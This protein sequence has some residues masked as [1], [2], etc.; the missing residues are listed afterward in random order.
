MINLTSTKF[1]KHASPQNCSQY[2]LFARERDGGQTEHHLGFS[3]NS[4]QLFWVQDLDIWT[5]WG[6]VTLPG[7]R[8]IWDLWGLGRSHLCISLPRSGSRT[9]Y[10]VVFPESEFCSGSSLVVRCLSFPFQMDPLFLAVRA[11]WGRPLVCVGMECPPW[12][13]AGT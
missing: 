1:G 7:R 9:W 8:L 6:E 2:F 10:A 3:F 5:P 12:L 11:Q 13:W 4:C